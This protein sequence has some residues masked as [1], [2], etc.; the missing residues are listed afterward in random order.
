MEPHVVNTDHATTLLGL[1]AALSH[2]LTL[3][4]PM[5]G[6]PQL[7]PVAGVVTAAALGALG[8]LANKKAS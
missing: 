8:Y 2:F 6:L 1:V 3:F 5:F 7:A 4:A